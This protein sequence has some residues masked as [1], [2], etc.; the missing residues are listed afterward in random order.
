MPH[1]LAHQNSQTLKFKLLGA[2]TKQELDGIS[3]MTH[4]QWMKRYEDH[5][6]FLYDIPRDAAKH[7]ISNYGTRSIQ[8]A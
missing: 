5:F 4:D 8:I 2:Y 1:E 7:L 3:T 6:V